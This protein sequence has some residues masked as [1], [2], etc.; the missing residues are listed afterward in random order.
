M[1]E[2]SVA[3]VSIER[4]T[5][6]VRRYRVERPK[7]FDF[8]P[9]Q[10]TELSLEDPRWIAEKR[11]FTFTSL[12]GEPFLEFT[13]K[14]YEERD[15]LTRALGALKPGAR[16]ILREA[17]G[18]IRF[19]GPG[20]FLAAGAGITPFIA[21][22][23]QLRE[24]K[25]FAGNRLL[26]ANKRAEDLIDEGFWRSLLGEAFRSKLSREKVEGH[27]FGRIDPDDLEGLLRREEDFVYLCGP[28]SFV[29]SLLAMLRE[30]GVS[31]KRMI[32]EL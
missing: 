6:D 11:P 10:A 20:L 7:G 21:I 27:G 9:G 26:Y 14:S 23:K 19:A 17:W 29:E 22:F 8:Q 25:G 3:I 31:E 18:T 28:D 12:P 13:I 5:H 1:S 2:E 30:K 15:G 4:L 16:L 32:R 24:S